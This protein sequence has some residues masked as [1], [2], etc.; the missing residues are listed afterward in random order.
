MRH[1]NGVTTVAFSPDGRRIASGSTDK[2]IL[3]RLVPTKYWPAERHVAPNHLRY[4]VTSADGCGGLILNETR[5][6]MR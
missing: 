4:C 2:T 1:D 5:S 3:K 6:L